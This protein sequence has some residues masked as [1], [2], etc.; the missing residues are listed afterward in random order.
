MES[1]YSVKTH[2]FEGPLDTLLSLIEKRKL[3]INDISLA[4]VADDY[5]AYIKSF[6]N[7]PIADSA[8][9]IL[10]ASTLVLIKS[11][12]LLPSLELSED[13]QHSIED[14]ETRLKE[15]Q[16]YKELS[17]HLK[18]RFGIN[19]EY[20]RQPSKEK[21]VVFTPDKNT[22]VSRIF[23]TAKALILSLPKKEM[24]PKAVVQK[25]IS[26]EEMIENLTERIT[27]SMKMSFKDFAK[28]GKVEKVNVIVSF[29]A[30]LE[31]VKQGIIYVRQDKDFHDIEMQTNKIGIPTY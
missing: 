7:F 13:E 11:K 22:S 16:K 2:I 18:D 10:I 6:E 20:L 14:L 28:V 21:I 9:F 5:I 12:S 30:M 23:E 25:V 4:Q 3:F 1:S 31:L 24:V 8:H 26:L 15:Y 27:E 19:V 29:L 17:Q